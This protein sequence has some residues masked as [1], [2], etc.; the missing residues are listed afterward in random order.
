[1]LSRDTAEEFYREH[2]DKPFFSQLVDF[3]CR[4]VLCYRILYTLLKKKGNT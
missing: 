3:M 2:R 4:L 1:M